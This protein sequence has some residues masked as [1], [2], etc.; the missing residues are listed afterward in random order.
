MT[1]RIPTPEEPPNQQ[2]HD[3]LHDFAQ[4]ILHAVQNSMNSMGVPS[5]PLDT[6]IKYERKIDE[7]LAKRNR[8]RGEQ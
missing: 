2:F 4:E 7:L 8:E 6:Q 5:Y 1:E 3:L